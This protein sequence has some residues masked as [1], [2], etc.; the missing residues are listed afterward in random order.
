[1][2]SLVGSPTKKRNAD[3]KGKDKGFSRD[4]LVKDMVI[5]KGKR[6]REDAAEGFKYETSKRALL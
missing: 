2:G 1:M 3:Q 4:A 5:R 6:S